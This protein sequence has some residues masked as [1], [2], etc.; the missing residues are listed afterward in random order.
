MATWRLREISRLCDNYE[1]L[2]IVDEA[3]A[4]GVI[5]EKGEGLVQQSGLEKRCFARVHTFGK[6]V[7]THGAIVLGSNSLRDYLINF[8][9]PFI[10][11]TAMPAAAVKATAVSYSVFPSM[12]S[13]RKQLDHLIRLFRSLASPLRITDSVTPIQGVIIQGNE[14]ARAMATRLQANG[15]DIRAI[16]YPTVPKGAERLRIVL[17][18]FNTEEQLRDL[19]KALGVN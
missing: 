15:F 16:L 9:R 12:S 14:A 3:H 6:A 19:V 18:A 5:G 13:E 17:H 7:G 11:T 8:S 4:T 2:L 10:Y 1:A